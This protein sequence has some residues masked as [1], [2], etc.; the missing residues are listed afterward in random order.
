MGGMQ[1]L[2]P[3]RGPRE[4]SEA[5]ESKAYTPLGLRGPFATCFLWRARFHLHHTR[6]RHVQLI[7][8]PPN[9]PGR[10]TPTAPSSHAPLARAA[11]PPPTQSNP[12][13]A[14][15]ALLPPFASRTATSLPT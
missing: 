13:A 14:E 15:F 3:A 11:L 6:P 9:T 5:P 7:G 12:A 1:T 8:V 4:G 2:P 10:R